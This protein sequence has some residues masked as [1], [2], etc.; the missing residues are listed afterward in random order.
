MAS[1]RAREKPHP[2]PGAR[3]RGS[4][5][6]TAYGARGRAVP[7]RSAHGGRER[8]MTRKIIS[9]LHNILNYAISQDWV[10]TN[11]ARGI[12][13]I[14]PRDEGSKRVVAPSKAVVA[15]LLEAA[16]D[17]LR[18][19]ILFAASTGLR[20]GEQGAVRW[21]DINFEKRELRVVRRVDAYG[22]VG[23]PKSMAGV[24]TVPLSNALVRALKAWRL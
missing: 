21:A 1:V 24:R 5:A 6:V 12:R 14:G 18:I 10:A 16:N 7:G 23:A 8:A 4:T 2:A 19:R 13:V 9:T 17:D 15:K 22:D 11:S 3:H 20:A